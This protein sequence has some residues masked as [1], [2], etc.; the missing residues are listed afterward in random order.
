MQPIAEITLLEGP[1][2]LRSLSR[3]PT[4]MAAGVRER[5]RPGGHTVVLDL[6]ATG[7]RI[8]ARPE[9]KKGTFLWVRFQTLEPWP[10][11]VV[12]ND[13]V[14]AGC[15]FER[16]LHPAVVERLLRTS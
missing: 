5:G 10:A 12:W 2:E 11:K 16:P 9:F 8:A 15:G 7:C 6:S 4:K 14:F 1:A 3:Y 13:G